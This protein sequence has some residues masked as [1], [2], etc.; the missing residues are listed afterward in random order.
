MPSWTITHM[1]SNAPAILGCDDI[2]H[3]KLD[4]VFDSQVVHDLRNALQASM[5]SGGAEVLANVV[6]PGERLADLSVHSTEQTVIIE[7]IPQAGAQASTTAPLTLIRSMLARLK[8]A[9]SL[10]R[11]L[12]LSTTQIRAVTGFDRVMIYKFLEDGSGEVVAESVRHGLTPFLGLR[13]PESDIPAQ[14]RRLYMQ[15]WLRLIPDGRY[16]PAALIGDGDAAALDLSLAILRSVS[17][18]HLEYMRNMGSA[19]TLTVSLITRDRLWGLISCHHEVPRRVGTSTCNA[20]ELFGQI[21]SLQIEAKEQ[22]RELSAIAKSREAHERLIA[23]MPPEETLFDNLGRY[24]DLLQELIPCDGIGLWTNGVFSGVGTLPPVE[25]MPDLV[26]FLG[27]YDGQQV[28]VS[29]KI[30]DVFPPA[31]AYRDQASGLIAI[32]FSRAPRDFL[33]FFRKEILQVVTWGGNPHKALERTP[34]GD[35]LGPRRSFAA[36]REDVRG[37]SA[38]WREV[39]SKIAEALRTSLLDVILRRADLVERERRTAQES[40]ALL[41]AELNHRVKNILAL[42][43]SLVRQSRHGAKSVASFT[44]DIEQRIQA[45]A[46]AHDQITQ[47]NWAAAPLRNLLEAEAKIWATKARSALVFEGPQVLLDSRAFQTMALVFHELMTNAAK[48]GALSVPS[49]TLRVTWAMRED[50]SLEIVWREEGGPKV[51]PPSRRGFGTVVVEQTVPFELQGKADVTYAPEGVRARFVLPA[52]FISLK[53]DT[54]EAEDSHEWTKAADLS[55]K[56]ILLV[57]D[58]M[59]IALDAQST[60]QDAEIDAEVA[61]SVADAIRAVEIERFDAAVLDINLSGETSFGVADCCI[62]RHMPFV[63]ATGYGESV[64]IPDRFKGVPIVSKPYDVEMLR[65]ALG[66]VASPTH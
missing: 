17:P 4:D 8:K 30:S 64:I 49:G 39:E 7:I 46:M 48:Y 31:A 28:F 56:R 16:E 25:A 19:A 41:I 60:L 57:E 55:G 9:P 36:W 24:V 45:L 44:K 10:E 20:C 15:Q 6:L 29:D 13:Y 59:M 21:F 5:V 54:E 35:R 66:R 62:S 52:S 58:S 23:S 61:G 22:E 2:L 37:T 43:R 65:D 63:F 47:G 12:V 26:A 1:S 34:S 51:I 3:R 14:A 18:I 38:S 53:A 40:Q 27:Q 33:F 42:I 50:G 32:P 11:A